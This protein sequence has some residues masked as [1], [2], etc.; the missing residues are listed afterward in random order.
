[1]WRRNKPETSNWSARHRRKGGRA[2]SHPVPAPSV[3]FV[4]LISGGAALFVAEDSEADAHRIMEDLGN[5]RGSGM[6]EG[7]DRW[8]RRRQEFARELERPRS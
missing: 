6:I 7:R 5:L 8:A 3:V 1:M 4:K 2:V